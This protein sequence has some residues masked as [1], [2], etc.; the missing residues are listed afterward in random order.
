MFKRSSSCRIIT[1]AWITCL[2]LLR[3][4]HPSE[5]DMKMNLLK[6]LTT[7]S[8][9]N[10][11]QNTIIDNKQIHSNKYEE[12]MFSNKDLRIGL[13]IAFSNEATSSSPL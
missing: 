5:L 6:I 7:S 12:E 8:S 10:L 4:I 3:L 2:L 11:L 9:L 13:K 1:A